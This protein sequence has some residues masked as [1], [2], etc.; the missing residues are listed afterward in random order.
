M[1][2]ELQGIP[3][4]PGFARGYSLRWEPPSLQLPI[5]SP[6]DMNL[7]KRRLSAA[8]QTA[9]QQLRG[10]VAQIGEQ[11][12]AAE[13]ALFEAQAMFLEDP[14]LAAR[15]ESLIDSGVNAEQAWQSACEY[16]AGQLESLADE[17]LRARSAD[18]RDVA[19]RV[20]EVLMGVQ[21]K[22]KLTAP[23]I[24]IAHDLAPSQTVALDATK[25]LA[26]CTAEGGPTSH[27]AILAKALGI[28]AVVGLGEQILGVA[29]GTL[30]LVDGMSGLVIA[31]PASSLLD[32]FDQRVLV[33][34]QRRAHDAKLA[35]QPAVTR[36]GQR[37]EIVANAGNVDDARLALE[38][39]AEGIGLLRTEFL[40]LNRS[41]A[42]DEQTQYAAYRTI[43]ELM[44]TRPLVARTL[45]I[46]GDKEAPYFDFGVEANPFLGYRAI[47]ISLDHPQ[48]FKSQLRALLR[49]GAG[50][51]LRIMFPMI[52]TL[53]EVSSAR[54]LLDEAQAELK[55]RVVDMTARVQVGIMVE[56]PSVVMLADRF[57]REVD[58]FSVGTNDLTQYTLAA[59]RGNKRLAHLNDSCHPAVLKEIQQVAVAAQKAGIWVGVCGE[60]AG[61]LQ[62]I[63]LLLG[64]GVT[65]LSVAPRQI[66]AVKQAVRS[67]SMED[68][69]ALARKALELD[70]AQAVRGI[71]MDFM[72]QGNMG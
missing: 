24:I 41:H 29:D 21:T 34:S 51:D 63:P 40:F 25:V 53:D 32:D 46:G 48:E 19:R 72:R 59:E 61:D 27:T 9:A 12:G 3:A 13:A 4:A 57:A 7:E 16:F 58:F 11:V 62:A 6:S 50:H 30:L 26:F 31:D 55:A 49:A 22:S 56:V 52:A 37:V 70:G 20:I 39:G 60:M 17:I 15:A 10:L 66:P 5:F 28:P 71:V 54:R 35:F 45:D 64:L 38:Q 69:Q 2:E 1:A 8:R 67:W 23:V 42:P 47:R 43:M 68:A 65:E 33:E 18:V 14:A 36:D 44:G